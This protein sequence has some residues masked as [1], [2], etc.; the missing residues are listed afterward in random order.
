M[1]HSHRQ[2]VTWLVHSRENM[3]KYL[4]EQL[5]RLEMDRIDFYLLHGLNKDIWENIKKLGAC[6]FL[7][8]AI[9]DG[10]LF[11][12]VFFIFLNFHRKIMKSRC[13]FSYFLQEGI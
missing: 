11:K 4:N 9:K 5:R 8:E 3:D 7:D 10:R 12:A 13:P 1:K 2:S 6:K